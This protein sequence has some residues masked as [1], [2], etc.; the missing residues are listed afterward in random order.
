MA[1]VEKQISE[2]RLLDMMR[3]E[4]NRN[5]RFELSL[6]YSDEQGNVQ[7][8]THRVPT[9]ISK[10]ARGNLSR[11]WN[12]VI[13]LVDDDRTLAEYPYDDRIDLHTQNYIHLAQFLLSI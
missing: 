5:S 3:N 10:D 8:F 11:G 6:A 12:R 2:D 1:H 13:T 4:K 7:E 9:L